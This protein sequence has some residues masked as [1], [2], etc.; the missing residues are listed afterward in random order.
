MKNF[1]ISLVSAVDRRK[2]IEEQFDGKGISF[3]FFD[4][5]EPPQIDLQ[6]EKIGFTLRQS[7]LSRNELACL[8]S[9]VSLW[10]KAVDEKIPAIAIFEDDIHL[11]DDAELFLKGSDWLNFDIVKIEKSYTSVIMD[12]D[13]TQIFDHKDF[14][15]RRLKKAHLGAAGYILSYKG[16][17]ELLDY[18]K[19]QSVL[20]HVDQIVFR[21]Y[22][23]DGKLGI[24]QL[25]PTLCIQDYILNPHDQKFKTSLQWRNKD[26]IK[27]KGFK[28]LLRE[29]N[30]LL[31]QLKESP[32]KTKLKFIS[33]DKN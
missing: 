28:K 16:A 33:T 5:I 25:N 12:L 8:L 31:T 26:K 24:Y 17:I 15:L 27:L 30:R 18:M 22:I 10:H 7:D 2:H 20:D 21:K 4:A 9:H 29:L 23:A 6:A 13:K 3:D 1:V 11:S 19:E 32:Y 14:I